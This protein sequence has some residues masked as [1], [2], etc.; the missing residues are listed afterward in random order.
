MTGSEENENGG[1]DNFSG[2][3]DVDVCTVGTDIQQPENG[4]YFLL[5]T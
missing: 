1:D 4:L 2:A 3:Q 5:E